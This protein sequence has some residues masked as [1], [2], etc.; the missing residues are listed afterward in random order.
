M[1]CSGDAPAGV[2]VVL[3][4][5]KLIMQATHDWPWRLA[6]ACQLA[7]RHYSARGKITKIWLLVLLEFGGFAS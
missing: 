1:H 2:H 6:M 5:H 7:L 3:E 4:V